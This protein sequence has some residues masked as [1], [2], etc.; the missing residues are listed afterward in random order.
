LEQLQKRM[1]VFTSKLPE[2]RMSTLLPATK[3]SRPSWWERQWIPIT[4]GFIA[5]YAVTSYISVSRMVDLVT[6]STKNV[7]DTCQSFVMN[8]IVEPFVDMW[9]TIRHKEARLAILGTE[10]VNS[11]LEVSHLS[12]LFI[13][14]SI[15]GEIVFGEDGDGFC[16]GSRHP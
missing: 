3:Y 10:S 8:W 7:L 9:N 15:D 16:S 6:M 12:L 1:D 13:Q 2:F 5:T 11:D 14:E 4:A